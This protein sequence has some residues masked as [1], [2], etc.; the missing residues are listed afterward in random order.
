[1]RVVKGIYMVATLLL[2][3]CTG[4]Q[5]STEPA[6][7]EEIAPMETVSAKETVTVPV[8]EE[9]PAFEPAGGKLVTTGKLVATRQVELSFKTSGDI[10]RIYVKNGQRVTKG[11][12][13]AELDKFALTNKTAQAKDALERAKLELQDVLIGQGYKAD[14]PDR[15]P[16]EVMKLARVK[17]GYEQSL[18]L[19]E[20]ACREE[21]QAV[22]VAPFD[23]TVANMYVTAF[24]AAGADKVFCTLVGTAGMEADFY[25]PEA[26]LAKLNIDDKLTI[27][28]YADN[29]QSYEGKLTQINPLVDEKGMVRMRATVSG[30]EGRLFSGM[31]VRIEKE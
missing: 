31:S 27:T 29:R 25:V 16:A 17:S 13:L 12:K 30:Q 18:C 26:E 20:L 21:E 28:P 9:A 4:Q 3:G 14:E 19:Y 6:P 23:G 24:T 7:A 2:A 10:A 11:Q 15:I 8:K 5:V 22:L 1:M